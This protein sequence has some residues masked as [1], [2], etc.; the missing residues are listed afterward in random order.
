MISAAAGLFWIVCSAG[1]SLQAPQPEGLLKF[2]VLA[3]AQAPGV[4]THVLLSLALILVFA[5]LLVAAF[6]RM[7]QPQVMREMIA[8]ILLGPSFLGHI[9]PGV[10]AYLFPGSI[11]PYL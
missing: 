1:E 8:G 11:T 2:G 9:A 6:R 7:S 3:P 4:L 5:R 10:A